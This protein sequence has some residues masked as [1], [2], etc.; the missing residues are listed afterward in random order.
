[1]KNS[2]RIRVDAFPVP[3]N[4]RTAQSLSPH[5][6]GVVDPT[7]GTFDSRP[8]RNSKSSMQPD[9]PVP[10]QS[11]GPEWRYKSPLFRLFW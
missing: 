9:I 1:M 3:E 2:F 4:R 6:F 8:P 5:V 11:S 7:R 10:A